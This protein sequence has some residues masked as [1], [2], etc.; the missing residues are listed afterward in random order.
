MEACSMTIHY[1]EENPI[2]TLFPRHTLQNLKTV[3][4]QNM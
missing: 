3:G 2:D 4:L 1:P